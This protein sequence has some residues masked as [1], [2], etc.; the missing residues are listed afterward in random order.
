M[1]TGLVT[2]FFHR[3]F[4]DGSGDLILVR[5][6][7][8]PGTP[9]TLP[10]GMIENNEDPPAVAA[11]REATEEIGPEFGKLLD[12]GLKKEEVAV[13]EV[14]RL[15]KGGT[16]YLQTIFVCKIPVGESLRREGYIEFTPGKKKREA[17]EE[18]G[19][20][21]IRTF[22]EIVAG[23]ACDDDGEFSISALHR[24]TIWRVAQALA[25]A[26]KGW[27]EFADLAAKTAKW[28]FK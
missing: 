17:H 22:T 4:S 24:D 21:E 11:V 7:D 12:E 27:E 14:D 28:Q 10:G 26:G 23:K 3:I 15:G 1:S 19:P 13:L 2:L 16:T 25:S 6:I 18:L 20:P 9:W 8:V 5:K